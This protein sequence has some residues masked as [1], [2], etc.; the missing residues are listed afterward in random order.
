[1]PRRRPRTLRVVGQFEIGR[2]APCWDR[3]R[4]ARAARDSGLNPSVLG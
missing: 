3:A 2:D 1:M 4:I